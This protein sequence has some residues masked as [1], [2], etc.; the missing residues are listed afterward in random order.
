MYTR[1]LIYDL[2]YADTDDY[3]AL[4]NYLQEVD[5]KQLSESS[6]EV[7]TSDSWENFRDK[8]LSVTKNGDNVKAVVNCN[9]IEVRT[10]R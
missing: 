7:N 3:N 2:K 6:Y 1:I 4:Y 8:M 9:G 10:I 5:A